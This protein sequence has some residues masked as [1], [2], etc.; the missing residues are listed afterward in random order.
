MSRS[1]TSPSPTC[2][3]SQSQATVVVSNQPTG[4][5]GSGWPVGAGVPGGGGSVTYWIIA[6]FQAATCGSTDEPICMRAMRRS[7]NDGSR[8]VLVT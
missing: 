5:D 7:R 2:S 3:T 4:D 1:T 8:L 6:S